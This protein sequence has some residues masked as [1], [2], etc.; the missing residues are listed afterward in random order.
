MRRA[1]LLPIERLTR[2]D[3]TALL[4]SYRAD[5]A[6]AANEAAVGAVVDWC[7]GLAVGLVVIGVYME[8]HPDLDWPAYAA[9]LAAK[10]ITTLR[11]TEQSAGPLDDY[12]K[13]VDLIR[14]ETL[15]S[16]TAAERRALTYAALLPPDSVPRPWIAWLLET[17]GDLALDPPPGYEAQPAAPTVQALVDQ[18]LLREVSET[19]PLLAL[20]R[21]QALA[22]DERVLPPDHPDL[23]VRYNNLAY[24]GAGVAP[25]L[26]A[27]R[28]GPAAA[29]PIR[30]APPGAGCGGR[31]L[32]LRTDR[33]AG[34]ARGARSVRAQVGRAA[35][36]GGR[37][38]APR[39][40]AAIGAAPVSGAG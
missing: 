1:A 23:A 14:E 12:E 3:G 5:A 9:I 39:P 15:S 34:G 37:G 29:R 4:A 36:A 26:A 31:G 6:A 17:D 8:R 21:V 22:I 38:G 19:E 28:G 20:H 2:A 25:V 11:A 24:I 10:G 7:D 33:G 27:A 30:A 40:A 35:R 13:R 32:R 16:L 18:R